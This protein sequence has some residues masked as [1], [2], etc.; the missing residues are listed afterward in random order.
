MSIQAGWNSLLGMYGGI[1]ALQ[2]GKE[3]QEYEQTLKAKQMYD[4]EITEGSKEWESIRQG[5]PKEVTTEEIQK[6]GRDFYNMR[7]NAFE[8]KVYYEGMPKTMKTAFDKGRDASVDTQLD[9][10]GDRSVFTRGLLDLQRK[11]ATQKAQDAA[12]VADASPKNTMKGAMDVI[13]R[14]NE[15]RNRTMFGGDK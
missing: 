12:N 2:K 13:K 9:E 4:Q 6:L 5:L 8:N 15:N 10:L 14:I 11:Y 3:L 1:S 7:K